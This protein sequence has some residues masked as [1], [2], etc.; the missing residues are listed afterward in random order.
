MFVMQNRDFEV[1]AGSI[2]LNPQKHVLDLKLYFFH[3]NFTTIFLI[4]QM[5]CPKS[6]RTTVKVYSYKCHGLTD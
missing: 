1:D 5:F 4:S 2:A 3:D 6:N